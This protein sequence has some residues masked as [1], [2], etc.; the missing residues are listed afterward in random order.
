MSVLFSHNIH[1][2]EQCRAIRLDFSPSAIWV[3]IY[4]EWQGTSWK[5][6]NGLQNM[7]QQ[8]IS[9]EEF[10]FRIKMKFPQFG[11]KNPLEHGVNKERGKGPI[12][13]RRL[14]KVWEILGEVDRRWMR[15]PLILC[16][17]YTLVNLFKVNPDDWSIA[18]STFNIGRL[19]NSITIQREAITDKI[20]ECVSNKNTISVTKR[21]QTMKVDK[22]PSLSGINAC[23]NKS[24]VTDRELYVKTK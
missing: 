12:T 13:P 5:W 17:H 23:Q 22:T 21:A 4:G 10:P 19:I 11:F 1:L 20:S 3:H 8:Q 14:Y 16:D 9:C 7:I 2:P 6:Q 24:D 15:F 18:S